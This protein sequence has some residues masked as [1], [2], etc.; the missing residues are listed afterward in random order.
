V[1]QRQD[2]EG[3]VELTRYP[4]AAKAVAD[5]RQWEHVLTF[6]KKEEMP[7]AKAKQPSAE[8][9]AEVTTI[10]EQLLLKEARKLA[11]DPGVVLPRRLSSAE[12]DY[13][14]H[15]LTGVDIRPAQ[16]SPWTPPL[17]KASP[18]RARR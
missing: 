6:L 18:T 17:A 16:S 9:R 3:G 1:S 4:T 10:V 12:Y 5:F 14:V 7:P 13:T 8:A 2:G 11:G 15:D